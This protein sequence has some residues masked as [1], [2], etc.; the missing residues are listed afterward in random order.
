[1]KLSITLLLSLRAKTT[2]GKVKH[3]HILHRAYA[4]SVSD[5]VK[6]ITPKSLGLKS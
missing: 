3:H 5:F 4:K 2:V 6:S 1:M